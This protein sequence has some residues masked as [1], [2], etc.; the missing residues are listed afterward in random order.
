ERN[1]PRCLSTYRW[2][3]VMANHRILDLP[4]EQRLDEFLVAAQDQGPFDLTDGTMVV[5]PSLTLATDELSAIAGIQFYE[6]RL[7]FLLL[8][9]AR[10]GVRLIM[11][12]STE[13]SPDIINYYLGLLPDHRSARERLTLLTLGDVR[14]LPLTTK[15]LDHPEIISRIRD[16]IRAPG[17]A[18]LL[19]FNVTPQ[20]EALATGIG[21]P[22]YGAPSRAASLGEKSGGRAVAR[23]AGVPVLE[24]VEDLR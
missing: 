7:L 2:S 6:E 15:L 20:E 11:I 13:I 18:Y 9:L 19:P 1:I 24:G 8:L 10:P 17:H 5:V 3:L 23:A 4:W 21:I 12:T 14:Q 16:S 22:I